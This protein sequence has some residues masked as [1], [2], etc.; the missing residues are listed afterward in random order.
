MAG[1][2]RQHLLEV[3]SPQ[4]PRRSAM[5]DDDTQSDGTQDAQ[6]AD[7][8]IAEEDLKLVA[9]GLD[10]P[11]GIGSPVPGEAGSVGEAW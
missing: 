2:P 9:G 10:G 6:I 7:E 1:G 11:P 3:P 4:S 5:A 8:E